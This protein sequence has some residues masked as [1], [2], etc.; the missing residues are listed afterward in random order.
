MKPALRLI[1][2]M[3]VAVAPLAAQQQ[4]VIYT[5]GVPYTTTVP[6]NC[7]NG[8]NY[9]GSTMSCA[10]NSIPTGMIMFTVSGACPA[11]F[12]EATALNGK[13]IIGT[14]TANMDVGTTGGSD[15]ITP[16][17]ASLT[18]AAQTVSSLSAAAQTVN[19]L[20]AAAQVHSGI[21]ASFTGQASTLTGAV[22]VPV[23]VGT[24]FSGIINHTHPATLTVQGAT[25]AINTG[26]HVLTSTATGGSARL[27][28][29]GDAV[30][31][32]NP[33]GG[34]ASITPAG[35]IAAP[36]LTMNSYTPNGT[37]AITSQ[38]TNGPSAVTGT[39]NP[40]AVTGT[41]NPSSVT[42]TLSQ[43]DNR[44]AWIKVIGCAKN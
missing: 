18:A 43:F 25:T 1:L 37:V 26:T 31:T 9:S 29:A 8:V 32:A 20:T 24:P 7:S 17:V 21:T 3:L 38:G 44:S 40:S 28:T 14:V 36:A 11:G 23:F 2:S 19:S 13:T 16:T 34:V 41:L 12:T 15:A 27:V 30:A 22:A 33:V 4:T 42:G 10:A 39:M 6:M 35:T 5:G